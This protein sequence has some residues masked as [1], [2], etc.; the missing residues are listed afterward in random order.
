MAD[1]KKQIEDDI[2]ENQEKYMPGAYSIG[3][4]LC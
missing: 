3:D 4:F 2:K 1:F